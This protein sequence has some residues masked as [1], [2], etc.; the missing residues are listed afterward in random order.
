MTSF[1]SHI[2]PDANPKA[3]EKKSER[4]KEYNLFQKKYIYITKE[5]GP[6]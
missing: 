1:C 4:K 3:A 6:I 5:K 2:K